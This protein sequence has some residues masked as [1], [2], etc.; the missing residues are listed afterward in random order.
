MHTNSQNT[1][2]SPTPS[3]SP[4][5]ALPDPEPEPEQVQE[6]EGMNQMEMP[7]DLPSTEQPSNVQVRKNFDISYQKLNTRLYINKKYEQYMCELTQCSSDISKSLDHTV[8]TSSCFLVTH[9]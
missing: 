5:R 7:S 3:S 2:P 4:A 1:C 6:E 8:L 9:A